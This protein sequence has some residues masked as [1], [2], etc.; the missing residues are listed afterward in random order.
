MREVVALVYGGTVEVHCN[1]MSFGEAEALSR[2][3]AERLGL[4]VP[5]TMT[6]EPE[7]HREDGPRHV[8]VVGAHRLGH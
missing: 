7:Q 6:Q 3:F 5:I 2:L 1:G 8:H 4:R